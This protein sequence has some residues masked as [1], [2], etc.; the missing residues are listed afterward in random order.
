MRSYTRNLLSASPQYEM[1]CYETIWLKPHGSI[2]SNSSSSFKRKNRGILIDW[3]DVI[4]EKEDTESF[5]SIDRLRFCFAHT[6]KIG[7]S[8][9]EIVSRFGGF[10]Q[11]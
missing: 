8:R 4:F 5:Y 9:G 11:L 6:S 10:T 7:A 3:P 2:I 1:E